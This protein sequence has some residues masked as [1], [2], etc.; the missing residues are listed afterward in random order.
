MVRDALKGHLDLLIMAS[1]ADEP[2]HGYALI[3]KLSARSDGTFDL[4]E[5]TI[6]PA[7]HKLERAGLLSSRWSRADGR[8]K[9]VYVLTAS[10]RK[11]LEQEQRA[12]EALADGVNLVLGGVP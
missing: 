3:R 6:Y 11:A 4:P 5:G 7:L 10:G 9:R 12:W 8:R 1:L 2:Q